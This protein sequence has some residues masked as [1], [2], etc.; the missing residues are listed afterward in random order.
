MITIVSLV[1][2]V[3]RTEVVAGQ[4]HRRRVCGAVP[5]LGVQAG[6]R[7]LVHGHGVRLHGGGHDGSVT[8]SQCQRARV[9]APESS[10]ALDTAR[11][12]AWKAG[13]YLAAAHDGGAG[14][15]PNT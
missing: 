15:L 1:R 13:N 10:S 5:Q 8:A 14:G 11:P 9:G 2:T 12:N 6:P 7:V 4:L 3:Y